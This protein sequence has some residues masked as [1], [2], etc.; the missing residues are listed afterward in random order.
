MKK[1]LLSIGIYC[2]LTCFSINTIIAQ[3]G[4]AIN[5]Q[6]LNYMTHGDFIYC[7]QPNYGFTDKITI[8]AW[9]KWTTDP[10]SFS[11]TPTNHENEGTYSTYVAYGSHNSRN[12]SS[13]NGQF[14]LRNAKTGNKFEFL[15]ENS[16]NT[17]VTASSPSFNPN[18]GQW[19]FLAGVYDGSNVILYVDGV[20]ANS[21]ALTGN[22]KS[23]DGTHRLVMGRLPWG[24]GFFV[25]YLDEVRIWNAALSQAQI[26]QQMASTA[27]VLPGNLK[28][29]WNFDR[30]TSTQTLIDDSGTQNADGTFYTCLIDVHS[31]TTSPYTFSDY[32]KTWIVNDWQNC[33]LKTVSGS[34]VDET[35]TVTSNTAVVCTLAGA[36]TATPVADGNNNM[37][38][39]GVEKTTETSQWGFQMRPFR[40]S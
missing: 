4:Y 37:T 28:S 23:N 17:I 31:L 6:N 25:G 18:Q 8:T 5:F 12:I 27:T 1:I 29:Y 24:Y 13:D 3:A 36:W 40:L 7:G 9:V 32:D 10:Q 16:S 39:F 21:A 2:L 11:V 35:N 33:A 26:Q 34:G 22:I 20:L 15:V 30:T 14:W 38:W 19:Y